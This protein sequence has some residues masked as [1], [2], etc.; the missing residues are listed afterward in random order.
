MTV[1]GPRPTVHGLPSTA[2]GPRST[3]HGLWSDLATLVMVVLTS[4]CGGD[5]RPSS[6]EAARPQHLVLIT[7]DTLR[8]DRV[9]SYGYVP[10]RTPTID[11]LA[12]EGVRFTHAFTTAPI[13]LPAHASL[14]TGRY[15]PGHGS[16]HNGL[17]MSTSVPTLATALQQAGF[18]TAAF[19]SAFPL[20]KRFGLARGFDVYDD[21]LPRGPDRKPLNERAGGESVRR[22]VEWL[23]TRATQR[24]FVWLHLFEP[25]APYGDAASGRSVAAR[26]D[27]E[28][29]ESD[30]AVARLLD[31]LGARRDSTLVVLAADHGEA[32]GEHGEIGH[33]VFVYD[34]TLRIP[35][36]MKGPGVPPGRELTNPVSL[37]DVAPTVLPMLGVTGFD[38]DGVS[39]VPTFQAERSP[40]DRLIYGESFA[41]LLDFGW[42]PLRTVR[43][44]TWKFIAA[45]RAELYEVAKDSGES[46]DVSAKDPQ[47][48]ARLLARV[49]AFSGIEPPS[50]KV[51]SDAARRLR[52]LGYLAG[53]SGRSPPSTRA[54]PKDR[55]Q[56]AS[57]L[58]EVTSGEVQ[59]EA[60]LR[61][62]QAII[63]D[64][65]ENP[66]AHL[67]LGYA[68]VARGRCDRAEPHLELALAARMPSAD[69]GLAL[70]DCRGRSDDL[71]GALR[72]LETARELE[73]GNPVVEANLGLLAL[74]RNDTAGAIQ[75]L[76]SAL[77]NDPDLLEARFAL[78]RAFSRAGRREE[79]AAQARTLLE[80]L[81]PDAPQRAEVQRL[82]EAVR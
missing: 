38:A 60:L 57:R 74:S 77:E 69:A 61:H 20:D 67:R 4:G 16:R 39:L 46:A 24:T 1:H 55:I 31:A 22:A 79:A 30:R 66:Q 17:A 47:R 41:P 23:A 21:Q 32:F 53:A 81:P 72:A 75:W 70:A 59:G 62:L 40:P 49:E 45:P 29:A 44:A 63:R 14:L 11:G 34:T 50:S 15:P 58:A 82:L 51:D 8:A 28:V 10:A 3:V 71:A 7:V 35:L 68:E 25:H 12:R 37:V 76:E 26:Y 13:T 9:G 18:S 27:D 65:P 2:H 52:S 42:S 19:V 36:V 33:S 56:V 43:D 80:Q 78:A 5:A 54:D 6:R 64:D 48:A 73:P